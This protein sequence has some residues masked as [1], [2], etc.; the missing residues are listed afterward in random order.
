MSL[1]LH[2]I[3]C[4][5]ITHPCNCGKFSFI[6]NVIKPV[7]PVQPKKEWTPLEVHKMTPEMEEEA[8]R[9]AEKT[10]KFLKAKKDKEKNKKIILY[11][12]IAVA[13]FFAYKKLF[14]K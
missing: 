5:C 14:K 10:I 11:V 7:N 6:N 1:K 13:G 3:P 4:Q 9:N 12:A 8:N 2:D